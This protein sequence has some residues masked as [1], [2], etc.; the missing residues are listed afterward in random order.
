M[1]RTVLLVVLCLQVFL[2]ISDF[3][4]TDAETLRTDAEQNPDPVE[5]GHKRN[6]RFGKRRRFWGQCRRDGTCVR[7]GAEN[8]A[9]MPPP[10]PPP[11]PEFRSAEW[12]DGMEGRVQHISRKSR[13]SSNCS[14]RPGGCSSLRVGDQGVPAPVFTTPPPP[15]PYEEDFMPQPMW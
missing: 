11:R 12:M 6:D 9:A 2:L 14:W 15:P 10:P 13:P 5:R 1:N 8:L 3:T 4:S 7:P